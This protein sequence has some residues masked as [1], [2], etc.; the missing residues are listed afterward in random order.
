MPGE[1]GYSIL[2][3][4][5]V[6]QFVFRPRQAFTKGPLDS[7]DYSIPVES[8]ISIDCRF[9][10]DNPNSPSILFFHGNGEVVSDYDGIAPLY[11]Q[12]GINLFVADY[13]GY[14]SSGGTPSFTSMVGDAHKIFGAFLDIRRHI[15]YSGDVWVMGR[16]LGSIS[17]IELAS[18]HQDQIKGLIVESGF[19]SI[20]RLVEYLGFPAEFLGATDITF[21]NMANIRSIDLPTL[22]LH[23]EQDDLIP[24]AEARDLFENSATKKKR[25]VI[26][27]G[28]GHNDIM[29]VDV[30]SYFGTIKEFVSGG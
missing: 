1:A 17:A 25:L 29:V 7:T 11:N 19:A 28:A 24:V 12:I 18:D 21:P 2:D 26:I 10:I 23:G 14:G 3:R 30:E 13:R 27:D 15:R 22:I 4:P 16:S 8:G 6:L 9:Y 20:L 5:E